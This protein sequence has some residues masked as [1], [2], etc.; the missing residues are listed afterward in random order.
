VDML[1]A[2]AAVTVDHAKQ[3][4]MFNQIQNILTWVDPAAVFISDAGNAY[5]YRTGIHNYSS[6]PIYGYTWDFYPMYK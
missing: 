3:Q 1:L 5:V 6:N 2:Q 4:Q